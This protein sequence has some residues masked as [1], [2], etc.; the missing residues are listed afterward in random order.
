VLSNPDFPPAEAALL[1]VH[2]AA[3]TFGVKVQ[4]LA[5]GPRMRSTPHL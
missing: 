4:V 2:K 1:D 5:R 3:Q